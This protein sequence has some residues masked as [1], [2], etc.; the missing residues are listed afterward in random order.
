MYLCI[1]D[2]EKHIL[3]VNNVPSFYALNWVIIRY[4]TCCEHSFGRLLTSYQQAALAK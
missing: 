3:V 4:I 2:S 1:L